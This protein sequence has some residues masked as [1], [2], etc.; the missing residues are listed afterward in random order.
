M[1][2]KEKLKTRYVIGIDPSGNYEEGSGTTGTAIFDLKTDEIIHTDSI[3]ATNFSCPEEFW[4]EHKYYLEGNVLFID[5]PTVVV[6]ED[7]LLYNSKAVHQVN[8]RFE[9]CQLIG[10]LKDFLWYNNIPYR[11]QRAVD[12]KNRWTDEILEKK[13]YIVRVADTKSFEHCHGHSGYALPSNKEHRLMSHELDAI[14]HAVHFGKF[15]CEV[16]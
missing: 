3:P 11:M 6:I 12:V 1:S 16:E 14:R 5:E 8:S 7:Y 10:I 2:K 13:G 9:T 15:Y 4:H